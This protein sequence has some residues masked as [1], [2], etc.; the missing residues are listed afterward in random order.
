MNTYKEI[1]WFRRSGA[2]TGLLLANLLTCGLF[3]GI[4]IVVVVLLTGDVYYNATEPD[5]SLKK[6]RATNKVAAILIALIYLA[7]VASVIL[8]R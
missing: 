5:G 2:C 1:P 4:L 7:V 3:P 6:W 8:S